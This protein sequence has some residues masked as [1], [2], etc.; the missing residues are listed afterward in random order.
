MLLIFKFRPDK[1]DEYD[2]NVFTERRFDLYW[3]WKKFIAHIFLFN[4]KPIIQ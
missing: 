4:N 1:N 2:F 3:G